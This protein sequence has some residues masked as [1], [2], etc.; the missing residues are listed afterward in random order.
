[1]QK[2]VL[3]A[4]TCLFTIILLCLFFCRQTANHGIPTTQKAIETTV[5]PATVQFYFDGKVNINIASETQLQILDG[6]GPEL[7]KRIV[8]HRK[9]NGPFQSIVDIKNVNGIGE[10][11]Y[12]AIAKFIT[13]GG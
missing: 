6:I 11:K 10:A 13:V 8:D 9:E 5:S 2:R 7:A 3:P 1:M 4:I 12:N